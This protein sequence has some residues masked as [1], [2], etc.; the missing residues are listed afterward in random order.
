MPGRRIERLNEQ[1][2][3]EV[4]DILRGSVKDPR[5]G[6]VTVTGARVAP[7]LTLARIFIS[8]PGDDAELLAG[9]AAATPFIRGELGRRLRI[10]RVPELRFEVDRSLEQAMRIE[11]LLHEARGQGGGAEEEAPD[12][13]PGDADAERDEP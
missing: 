8:V 13:A 10:R 3:R 11:E 4:I 2:R 1:F 9:L 7:D 5:V 12:D 6:T